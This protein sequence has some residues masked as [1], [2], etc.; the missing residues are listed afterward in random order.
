MSVAAKMYTLLSAPAVTA[1]LGK[2]QESPYYPSIFPDVLKQ[3]ATLPA[4]VF[5]VISDVPMNKVDGSRP[6]LRRAR[7]QIDC[8]ALH[9][10][11]AQEV[12]DAVVDVLGSLVEDGFTSSELDREDSYD[13]AT[14]YHRVRMDF[15]TWRRQ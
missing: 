6:T 2:G 14:Q 13:D 10:D 9:L 3:G 11:D 12:A 8:Y 5:N 15:A 4:I 1:L 7:V